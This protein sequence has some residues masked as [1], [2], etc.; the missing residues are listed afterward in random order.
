M[1]EPGYTAHAKR[2]VL[3]SVLLA[4]G[5]RVATRPR[6]GRAGP[7]GP[8]RAN[9]SLS[10]TF[11]EKCSTQRSISSQVKSSQSA[12]SVKHNA[13]SAREPLSLTVASDE[14][15]CLSCVRKIS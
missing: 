2:A 5:A 15:I 7:V 10:A 11:G 8:T 14:L 12:A 1:Q 9:I 3:F 4:F 13:Q 6:G